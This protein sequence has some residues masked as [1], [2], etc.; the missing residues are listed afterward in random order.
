[1][2]KNLKKKRKAMNKKKD[3]NDLFDENSWDIG[4]DISDS[5][6]VEETEKLETKNEYDEIVYRLGKYCEKTW[7]CSP[8]IVE[9]NEKGEITGKILC[10]ELSK[11]SSRDFFNWV[12]YVWPP[13]KTLNHIPEDYDS[14]DVR[15]KT[16][17]NLV[18]IHKNLHLLFS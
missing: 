18:A 11:A 3:M 13:A 8:C 1:M 14:F 2:G 17:I 6:F 5:V 16:F 10:Q 12:C 15:F 7:I 9:E 4:Q